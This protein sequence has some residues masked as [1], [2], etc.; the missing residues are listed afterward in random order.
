LLHDLVLVLRN[1]DANLP[2]E[3]RSK[4]QRHFGRG[5]LVTAAP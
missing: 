3:R 2:L 5:L 4:C 1:A